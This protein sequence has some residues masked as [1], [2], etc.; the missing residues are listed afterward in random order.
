[1]NK[2]LVNSEQQFIHF[3]KDQ[4]SS[5]EDMELEL[6]LSFADK[7]GNFIDDEDCDYDCDEI[8]YSQYKMVSPGL[9]PKHY[10]CL[11]VH[12]FEKGFDRFGSVEHRIFEYV[13]QEDFNS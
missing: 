6:G 1:M 10:P 11:V 12:W 7:N 4:Y 5:I 3:M 2:N 8:N 9:M 13:Y